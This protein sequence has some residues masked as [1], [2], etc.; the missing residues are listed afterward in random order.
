MNYSETYANIIKGVKDYVVNNNLK[1]MVLGLSGGLD[2]TVVAAIASHVAKETNIPLIGVSLPCET[3]GSDENAIADMCGKEFCN[4]YLAANLQLTFESVNAFCTAVS[5]I[6]KTPISQGNIKARLR[7]ITLYDI[8]SKRQGIV[9]D[10]DNLSEYYLGFFT[11]HGD[12]CDLTPI[13]GLWKTEVYGLAKWMNEGYM[14]M[15]EALKAAIEITPTDGN[16]VSNSDMD[17]IAPSCTYTEVDA[18]L[19]QWVYLDKKIQDAIIKSDFSTWGFDKLCEKYGKD[20]V[21]RV[22]MRSV[23]SEFKRRCTP[24]KINVSNGKVYQH[25]GE[26]I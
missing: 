17:Q 6:T 18:I 1:S 15:S 21:R 8:A 5:G 24:L 19:K 25:N 4:E 9:L 10:S 22:I 3:N 12:S 7:M 16:G 14:Y 13:G 11:L 2:S 20:I 26:K 23:N